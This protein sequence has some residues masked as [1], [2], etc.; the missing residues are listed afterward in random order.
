MGTQERAGAVIEFR[1]TDGEW[2]EVGPLSMRAEANA[3]FG[4]SVAFDGSAAVIGAPGSGGGLGAAWLYHLDQASDSWSESSRLAAFS[5]VRGDQ[6][7]SAVAIDGDDVWAGAPAPRGIENGMAYVFAGTA[8]DPLAGTVRRIRYEEERTG[9]QD[10]LGARVFANDGVAAVMASGVD[11]QAGAVFVFER[12][13]SGAWQ[14][15]S[16]LVSPPDA[17]E[18]MTGEERRCTDGHVGPFDC[19]EVELL[20]FV[21]SSILSAPEDARGIRTNDNWGW[22]DPETRREYALVGRNDGTAFIDITDPV[23]PVLVGD[24]PKTPG[25]PRSQLWRDIKTYRGHAFI[26][27]DGAGEHGMQVFDLTRLRDVTDPPAKFTP[28]VLYRGE[29]SNALA[30]SHN[31]GIN[32]ETG[33]AYLIGGGCGGLH[34][35]DIREPL[36]PKFAGCAD[37]GGTHD[38]QCLNYRGPDDRFAGREICLRSAA[39]DFII[40]DVTD[41]ANPRQLASTTHPN[42]AYLHQGWVT[43]D[44]RYF[45]MDDESDVIRGNVETTRTLI[46]DI[47]DLED[48]RLANEFMGSMPASAHNLYIKDGFAYQANYRY[49]LHI[50]DV[51]DP[52]NPREVGT[53]DTSPYQTGPGFSGAWSTYPFFESGTVI[54][55]SLQEGLFILKKRTRPVS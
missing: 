4:T 25:T 30:S 29:G 14:E 26:V 16:M 49:G 10:G 15:R 8:D 41:K 7:A 46:W 17:L 23:N 1:L 52:L 21:P 37:P 32:E 22:T 12:D 48:P 13:A 2:R 53:F 47:T 38:I 43:D 54:V 55:T 36:N 11:H 42:P 50:I 45:I 24:L 9:T 20:A 27:A 6:F 39:D 3:G 35:V 28:D 44:H 40:S 31:I 19:G 5:G 18:S 51:S 34:M 33:Y